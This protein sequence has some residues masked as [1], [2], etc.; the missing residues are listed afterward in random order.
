MAFK[1]HVFGGMYGEAWEGWVQGG[2]R[3]IVQ[4]YLILL[5]IVVVS[6]EPPTQAH[7]RWEGR[8]PPLHPISRIWSW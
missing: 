6:M 8:H 1:G 4:R 7:G 5:P 2:S 3:W